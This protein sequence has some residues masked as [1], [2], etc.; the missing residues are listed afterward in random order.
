[1]RTVKGS[2]V[3]W[4]DIVKPNSDDISALKKFGDFHP[5]IL[6]ELYEPSTQSRVEHYDGYLFI[7]FH[8][9]VYD[10]I[11]KTSR[12]AEI[13]ILVTKNRIITIHYEPLEQID[14]LFTSLSHEETLRKEV[15]NTETSVPLYHIAQSLINF[16]T[17]QLRHI[18]ERVSSVAQEI[19]KENENELLKKISY[20]KRDILDYRL[21]AHPQVNIFRSLLDLGVKFWGEKSRVYLTDLVAD[22]GHTIQNLENYFEIIESLET[23]NAQLLNTQT[24]SIIKRLTTLAFLFSLPLYYIFL[25]AIPH[26]QAVI[27]TPGVFWTILVLIYIAVGVLA[28]QFKK[29]KML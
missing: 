23:T 2:K 20:I 11:A 17:R 6:N 7:V 19:F 14:T 27:S 18:E 21:I 4:I 8:V 3:T 9:P 1:M 10:P 5:I 24:N 16:S 13:D 25:M 26:V 28:Y 22:N 15:L 12:R 29:R